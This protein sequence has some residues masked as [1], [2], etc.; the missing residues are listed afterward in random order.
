MPKTFTLG[1][2]SGA[3]V[4]TSILAVGVGI[5][6]SQNH[7]AQANSANVIASNNPTNQPAITA[8]APGQHVRLNAAG[9]SNPTI[10]LQLA[11]PKLV[12]Q[13]EKNTVYTSTGKL[14]KLPQNRPDLFAAWWCPHCHDALG[15]I[16][17]DG[18]L[19][20]FNLISIYVDGNTSSPVTSWKQALTLT[21]TALHKIDVN[22]PMDHIY[23]VM[24]D[25]P[26]NTE[27][28]G[29]PT[30]LKFDGRSVQEMVGAPIGANVWKMVL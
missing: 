22:I 12:S 28:K 8:S 6:I 17:A 25:S 20:K 21:E 4:A 30:L 29:V 24:P 7:Q 15:Q 18:K 1:V 10:N 11:N 19:G 2:T 26:I 13:V 23:L 5:T 9:S 14:V 27:I 3:I 16:K